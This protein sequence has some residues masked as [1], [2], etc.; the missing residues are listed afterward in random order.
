MPFNAKILVAIREGCD[1]K[2]AEF[3]K[4]LGISRGYLFKL[5][6]GAGSPGLDTVEMIAARTG[7]SLNRLIIPKNP[8]DAADDTRDY[9]IGPETRLELDNERALRLEQATR[10]LDL[11]RRLAEEKMTKERYWALI[12]LYEE[13]VSIFRDEELSK[14][15]RKEKIRALAKKAAKGGV[16]QFGEILRVFE[17]KRS[18]LR[19]VIG[20]TEYKCKLDESVSVEAPMPRG[21]ALMLRCAV[22]EYRQNGE[23][24]GYGVS[25]N[26]PLGAADIFEMLKESGFTSDKEQAKVITDYYY[27]GLPVTA[28]DVAEAKYRLRQGRRVQSGLR[29]LEPTQR[30]EK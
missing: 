17:F 7:L 1:M 21:A 29:Y 15:E 27:S 9:L 14:A 30:K 6:T 16:L 24:R 26:S 28:H 12:R 22:C 18:E 10:I 3:A 5:E 25:G 23:C 19:G 4:S 20:M 13:Y 11:E 8:E 2:P